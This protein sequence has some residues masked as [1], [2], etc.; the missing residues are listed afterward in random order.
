MISKE[1]NNLLINLFSEL[2]NCERSVEI[3][4]QVLSE[5]A[6]FDAHQIFN[7]LL[8]TETENITVIDT[9]GGQV[10]D[11]FAEVTGNPDEFLSTG[12]TMDCN[13]SL[14]LNIGHK[15]YTN[16]YNPIL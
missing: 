8:S 13:E 1:I 15:I 14:N 7:F 3:N 16:L 2:I 12:V 5:S 10:V 9:E 11:F 6:D 4:R